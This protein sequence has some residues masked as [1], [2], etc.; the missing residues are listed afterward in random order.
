MSCFH[1]PS[2]KPSTCTQNLN[3]S[4]RLKMLRMLQNAGDVKIT[5]HPKWRKQQATFFPI[6]RLHSKSFF[7]LLLYKFCIH[8]FRSFCVYI[9]ICFAYT[10]LP[11]FV[12]AK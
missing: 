11:R 5:D 1:I 7:M 12:Y 6:L 2:L 8:I 9:E 10:F 3:M 4:F